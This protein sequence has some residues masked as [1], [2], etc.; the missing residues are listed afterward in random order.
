[1][2]YFTNTLANSAPI[3]SAARYKGKRFLG[4]CLVT[5]NPIVTD[6]LKCAIDIFPKAYTIAATATAGAKA[7]NHRPNVP[8][9]FA[10]SITEPVA[11]TTMTNVPIN[12]AKNFFWLEGNL[13]VILEFCKVVSPLV[14][15]Y[16]ESPLLYQ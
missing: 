14:R 3:I 5:R 16:L 2:T 12:S 4:M 9:Y 1:M 13:F 8:T 10:S 11:N 6:G 15:C 7:T